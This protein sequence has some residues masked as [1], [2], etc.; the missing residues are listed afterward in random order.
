[1]P[2]VVDNQAEKFRTDPLM[3]ELS[4]TSQPTTIRFAGCPHA[5]EPERQQTFLTSC[6]QKRLFITVPGHGL[7]FDL[8][9]EKV[10]MADDVVEFDSPL[11]LNGVLVE[12]F[13]NSINSSS[14]TNNQQIFSIQVPKAVAYN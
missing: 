5:R 7:N 9:L 12:M 10:Q 13:R 8:T 1:M 2:L 14:R 11:I 3:V 6:Q 4:A